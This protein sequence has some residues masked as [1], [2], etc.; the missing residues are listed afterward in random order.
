MGILQCEKRG[1]AFYK[2]LVTLACIFKLEFL[3]FDS[4][5]VKLFSSLMIICQLHMF[6][7]VR[8][9]SGFK[10]TGAKSKYFGKWFVFMLLT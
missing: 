6:S 10:K 5:L 9:N 7:H 3:E 4:D 1:D 8:N 2:I